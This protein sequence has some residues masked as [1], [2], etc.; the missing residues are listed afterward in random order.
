LRPNLFKGI[1]KHFTSSASVS[2]VLDLNQIAFVSMDDGKAFN[3]GTAQIQQINFRT[4]GDTNKVASAVHAALLKNHGSEEDFS[5]LTPN[6]IVQLTDSVFKILTS[7]ISAI[8]SI[9]IIVGGVGIMNIMLV[10]VTERTREIGIR[11]DVGA[12]HMQVLSQFLARLEHS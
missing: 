2:N 10:S 6:E 4:E 12:T 8:A 1:L 3:Q 5:V 11:K 9:S 7:F